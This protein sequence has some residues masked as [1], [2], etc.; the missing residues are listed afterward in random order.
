MDYQ[1]EDINNDSLIIVP[2]DGL[3]GGR[4]KPK[5]LKPDSKRIAVAKFAIEI[6]KIGLN[7]FGKI[8]LIIIL[9][10]LKPKD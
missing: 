4:P 9:K 10:S 7:I 5:K 8:C 2:H 6:I 3:G 1:L